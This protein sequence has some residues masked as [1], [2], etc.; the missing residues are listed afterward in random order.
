MSTPLYYTITHVFFKNLSISTGF[1]PYISPL[2]FPYLQLGFKV[3][4]EY[5]QK[6]LLEIMA[7]ERNHGFLLS[8]S[9]IIC[10]GAYVIYSIYLEISNVYS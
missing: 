9:A 6:S 1:P 2:E 8:A 3:V 4:L 5:L 10:C 7:E